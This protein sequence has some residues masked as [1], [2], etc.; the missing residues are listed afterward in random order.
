MCPPAATGEVGWGDVLTR[1]PPPPSSLARVPPDLETISSYLASHY[2]IKDAPGA[3]LISGPA[4]VTIK[5]WSAPTLGSRP[6]DSHAAADGSIWWTG[7]F[8]SKLGRLDPKTGQISEFDVHSPPHG[9][10]EDPQGNIWFT[11]IEKSVIGRLDP[12]TG[13]AKEYPLPPNAMPHTVQLDN[14]G[15][16]WFSGNKNGTIGWI[17]RTHTPLSSFS[18]TKC[19]FSRT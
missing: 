5:E 16:P 1:E 8:A 19:L 11:G 12:K 7:M 15:R 6:H 9:L 13:Q 17:D 3:V 18:A 10:A 2:P 14:K 4:T